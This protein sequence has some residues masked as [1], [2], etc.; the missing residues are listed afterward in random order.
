MTPLFLWR[1]CLC[2]FPSCCLGLLWTIRVFQR[3]LSF[4]VCL[5]GALSTF[6]AMTGTRIVLQWHKEIVVSVIGTEKRF[7]LDR[8]C[9]HYCLRFL[10]L[11]IWNFTR[12]KKYKTN[13]PPLALF[14]CLVGPGAHVPRPSCPDGVRVEGTTRRR[15]PL[16]ATGVVLIR[17]GFCHLCM[18]LMVTRSPLTRRSCPFP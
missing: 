11:Y 15:H 9:R 17:N 3:T 12:T 14:F 8:F 1:L 16:H 2:L 18:W 7:V 10:F 5:G 6:R 13:A 4:L